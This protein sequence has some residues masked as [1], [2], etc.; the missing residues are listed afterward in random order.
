MTT[1]MEGSFPL[2]CVAPYNSDPAQPRGDN[3]QDGAGKSINRDSFSVKQRQS[4]IYGVPKDF[5]FRESQFT[6]DYAM[7]EAG[8]VES[9]YDP[10]QSQY[11][12][13]TGVTGM[14]GQY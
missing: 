8:D 5:K 1:K 10:R 3:W 9:E 2:A 14:T 12:V 4:S 11:T 6:I 13:A 7:T